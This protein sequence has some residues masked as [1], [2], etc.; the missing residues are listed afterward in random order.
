MQNLDGIIKITKPALQLNQEPPNAEDTFLFIAFIIILI[1]IGIQL[2][3]S[4]LPYNNYCFGVSN[5]KYSDIKDNQHMFISQ[6]FEDTK[7]YI[8]ENSN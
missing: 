2:I 5:K 6:C 8:Y 3:I 1:V 7:H 4:G